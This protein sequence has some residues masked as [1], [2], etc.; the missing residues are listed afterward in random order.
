MDTTPSPQRVRA[1]ADIR[2]TDPEDALR[3]LSLHDQAP[4]GGSVN[5]SDYDHVSEDGDNYEYTD[6]VE[7]NPE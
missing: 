6:T 1:P 7:N 5:D 2:H 3:A 4:S